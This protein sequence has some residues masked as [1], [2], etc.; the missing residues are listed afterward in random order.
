[1]GR[2][3]HNAVVATSQ[4]LGQNACLKEGKTASVMDLRK[5][6]LALAMISCCVVALPARSDAQWWSSAPRDFEDCAERAKTPAT[7]KDSVAE[8]EAKFAGRR[9][10]GGGYTYYDFMQNRSFD[11]AGPNPTPQESRKIDEQYTAYLAAQRRDI[12]ASAFLRKQQ[13]PADALAVATAKPAAKPKPGPRI[14]VSTVR[15]T[16]VETCHG[17][18]SCSLQEISAKIHSIKKNLFGS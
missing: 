7:G 2:K 1:M 15:R 5:A 3:S 18:V 9:K 14:K 4:N 17:R 12:I 8:C 11:I 6:I 16:T 13:S 10:P